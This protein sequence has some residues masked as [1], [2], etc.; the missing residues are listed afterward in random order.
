MDVI[1]ARK[2][3]EGTLNALQ[4]CRNDGSFDTVWQMAEHN[5]NIIKNVIKDTK[6]SFKE[7]TVP[8]NHQPSKR[9]QALVAESSEEHT[10]HTTAIS[11]HR[12]NRYF[13]C[14]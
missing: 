8:P 11:H 7:A 9:L 4:G 12:A 6:F 13:R 3:A 5:S 14:I 10:H 1:S 2:T